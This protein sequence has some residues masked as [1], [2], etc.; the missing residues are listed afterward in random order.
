MSNSLP[1][2]VPRDTG[3]PGSV[4]DGIGFADFGAIDELRT[5]LLERCLHEPD[6]LEDIVSACLSRLAQI[7][8]FELLSV[9]LLDRVGTMRRVGASFR[10]D[11]ITQEIDPLTEDDWVRLLPAWRPGTRHTDVFVC[12][13]LESSGDD[14]LLP[15]LRAILGSVSDVVRVPLNGSSQTFGILEGVNRRPRDDTWPPAI[16]DRRERRRLIFAGSVLAS[17]ITT[18]RGR[19]EL[20]AL[21][22]VMRTLAEAEIYSGAEDDE[23]SSFFEEALSILLAHLQDYRAAILRIG[24]GDDAIKILAKAKNPDLAWEGWRDIAFRS[25]QYLAGHVYQ[26]NT[27]KV[28]PDV[29][30]QPHLFANLDWLRACRIRSAASFPLRHS[31]QCIGT[32]TVYTGFPYAFSELDE[33]LLL[34]LGDAFAVFWHRIAAQRRLLEAEE[35]STRNQM[36]R[37]FSLLH[38]T[39]N[40]WTDIIT[41]LS[42]PTSVDVAAVLAIARAELDTLSSLTVQD[43]RAER[44]IDVGQDLRK[45]LTA[46]QV[47]FDRAAIQV[48]LNIGEV[49][50]IKMAREEFNELFN[51]LISNSIRSIREAKREKGEISISVYTEA[52]EK[53]PELVITVQDNGVGIPADKLDLVFQQNF[54]TYAES[55]GTGLGLFIARDIISGYDGTIHAESREGDGAT[56]TIRLPLAWI[57]G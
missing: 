49:P 27:P 36:R 47:Q 56:L 13:D 43:T 55:G 21:A 33:K 38:S 37:Y 2:P 12:Q 50:P 10:G 16:Q 14:P 1:N 3:E 6:T 19:K 53:R 54:T 41:L 34:T 32:L 11:Q 46:R 42:H 35:A 29:G 31:G 20:V 18:W 40:R 8:N 4:P 30:S 44:T 23:I 52:K 45:L 9:Y 7:V 5:H 26:T 57:T 51:N 25:G 48:H 39:K 24:V 17:A 15:R 22:G 28:V